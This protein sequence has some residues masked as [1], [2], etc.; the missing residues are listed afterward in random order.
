MQ[1]M[2]LSHIMLAARF[3]AQH[4]QCDS[5]ITACRAHERQ[6]RHMPHSSFCSIAIEQRLFAVQSILLCG[7]V[8]ARIQA[9]HMQCDQDSPACTA[10]EWQ[11]R[12]MP[13][14]RHT[15]QQNAQCMHTRVLE[16][17]SA[18]Y[19][20][21]KTCHVCSAQRC[22]SVYNDSHNLCRLQ[23]DVS[24]T[25][26]SINEQVHSAYTRASCMSSVRDRCSLD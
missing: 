19:H 11:H 2:V 14:G 22:S 25:E 24:E 6:H 3:Q 21:I 20:T 9:Q 4:M 1:S 23:P 13:Q 8:A 7:M 10:Y 17:S 12:H 26:V 5:E 15:K 16:Q 18:T